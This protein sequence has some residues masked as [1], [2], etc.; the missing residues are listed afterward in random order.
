MISIYGREYGPQDDADERAHHA[1]PDPGHWVGL[2]LA[3]ENLVHGFVYIFF[4]TA[5]VDQVLMH[6]RPRLGPIVLA[7]EIHYFIM[8]HMVPVILLFLNQDDAGW[9]QA[10]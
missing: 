2:F 6:G 4:S 5:Q 8:L 10:K 3:R 9:A 7:Y 1:S